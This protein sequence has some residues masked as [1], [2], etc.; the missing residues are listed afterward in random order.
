MI[1]PPGWDIGGWCFEGCVMLQGARVLALES[2][3]Q[4]WWVSWPQGQGWLPLQLRGK[5]LLC[6]RCPSCP[7]SSPGPQKPWSR[8]P[9]AW[10]EDWSKGRL[11]DAPCFR[12][13]LIIRI[14]LIG[15]SVAAPRG[16]RHLGGCCR[17][18][19]GRGHPWV[20]AGRH[21]VV[22]SVPVWAEDPKTRKSMLCGG[23]E[24]LLWNASNSRALL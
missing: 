20:L 16:G 6:G 18:R 9:L 17:R 5:R 19:G 7:S 4:G 1:K 14:T 2:Q 12:V 23:D 24:S 22:L 11:W 15:A 10:K 8:W 3:P 13:A 21:R